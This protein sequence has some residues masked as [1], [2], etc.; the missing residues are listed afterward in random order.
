MF[1]NE[2]FISKYSRYTFNE[3]DRI[4]NARTLS[5]EK[6]SNLKGIRRYH[7]SFIR[8]LFDNKRILTSFVG[9]VFSDLLEI[10]NVEISE[11]LNP[12]IVINHSGKTFNMD[13]RCDVLC[14]GEERH[15]GI[16][17]QSTPISVDR[18]MSYIVAHYQLMEN[19]KKGVKE[20]PVI[21]V[22]EIVITKNCDVL[23]NNK[24][25]DCS[26]CA[27]RIILISL[28]LTMFKSQVKEYK[29]FLD[30]FLAYLNCET[31]TEL[32]TLLS[33]D[34]NGILRDVIDTEIE[35]ISD[36]NQWETYMLGCKDAYEEAIL[37]EKAEALKDKAEAQKAE[38][39]A[40]KAKIE[41]QIIAINNDPNLTA[42][43]KLTA[44]MALINS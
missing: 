38:A 21:K 31:K 39:E 3:V 27:D 41:A 9:G 23:G 40:L 2:K 15:L 13:F 19:H 18:I 12:C 29:N 8:F 17:M 4:E 43:E 32:Y 24:Y 20:D 14:N 34:E 33:K 30:F 25:K 35:F 44:I 26:N 1:N 6:F 11:L 10:H 5:L 7:D 28:D 36:S 22:V 37:R 16:E 42:E